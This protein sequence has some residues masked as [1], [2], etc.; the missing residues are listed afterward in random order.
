MRRQRGRLPADEGTGADN[1]RVLRYLAK[2]T[3]NPAVAAGID[4]RGRAFF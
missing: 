4:D 3:I 1:V 2:H